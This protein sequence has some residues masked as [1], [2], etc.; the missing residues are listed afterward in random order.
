MPRTRLRL[1]ARHRRAG[2]DAFISYSH[3]ADNELAAVLQRSLHGFARPWY[4]LR[5]MRVFRDVTN[6]PAAGL[7]STIEGVLRQS[8]YLILL[9]STHSAQ[10]EWVGREAGFWCEHKSTEAIL[11]ALTDGEIVWNDEARDF[12]MERTTALPPILAGRFA[13]EPL[14]VDLRWARGFDGLGPRHPRMREATATLAATIRGR[15]RDS[16]IGE[17]IRRHRRAIQLAAA[18]VVAIV[19]FAG[20]AVWQSFVARDQRDN[21]VEQASQA[22]ALALASSSQLQLDEHPK[23]ALL[24]ALEAYRTRQ[25]PEARSALVSALQV[26]AQSGADAVLRGHTDIARAAAFSSDGRTLVTVG[27][28][29]LVRRWKL[30][31]TWRPEP[32]LRGHTGLAIAVDLSADG[33][34]I[35]SGSWDGTV[36][37]WD[38]AGGAGRVLREGARVESVAFSPKGGL[39][40]VASGTQVEVWDY[41]ARR[42]LS[43]LDAGEDVDQVAFDPAG[44]TIAGAT[45]TSGRA[46]VWHLPTGATRELAHGS[47]AGAVA[48][49]SDGARLAVGG[50]DDRV[51]HGATNAGTVSIWDAASGRRVGRPVRT[52]TDL[53]R[54]IAFAAD[55]RTVWAAG[56]N[57]QVVHVD[58]VRARVV[59]ELPNASEANGV[60]GL[61][62]TRD[63][64]TLAVP[65]SDGSVRLWSVGP[66]TFGKALRGS[67]GDVFALA[68]SPHGE[69]VAAA[70]D[71]GGVELWDV[72]TGELIESLDVRDVAALAFDPSGRRLAFAGG[73]AIGLWSPATG[74][75][76]MLRGQVPVVSRLAF[77]ADGQ[78][79]ASGEFD[80][81]VR[82]WDVETKRQIGKPIETPKTHPREVTFVAFSPDGTHV[83]FA[84]GDYV[85]Q[86]LRLVEVRSRKVVASTSHLWPLNT[87]GVTGAPTARAASIK[88][89]FVTVTTVGPHASG[90]IRV[91]QATALAMSPDAS[92]LLVQDERG[93]V[94]AWDAVALKPLGHPFA[95]DAGEL[96][97]VAFSDDGRSFAAAGKHGA[98]RVWP[99]VFWR[100]LREIE[101]RACQAAGSSLP[102]GEWASAAPGI[103]YRASC[104]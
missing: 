76:S 85:E 6:L 42:R 46:F 83:G 55:G 21:A 65:A 25:R 41:A 60:W 47:I 45:G 67:T 23:T 66:R 20:A 68:L 80:G 99:N 53:I 37:L 34:T 39:L 95:A 69:T 31:G 71:R 8:G 82:L 73:G 30:D 5:A 27:D 59:G 100:S 58:P 24:L 63:R 33:E 86:E 13:E 32:P 43:T 36:R 81:N 1:R 102:R 101:T 12:D 56:Q 3:A 72:A 48:F 29:R 104:G 84:A 96:G 10:S 77:S 49:S 19:A 88:Y 18:T 17:D 75:V 89:P 62:I 14:L 2:Y 64:R 54:G 26:S 9:A 94:Q 98:V 22:T 79:L 11:I 35:A 7:Q 90:R 91:G 93:P 74:D 44:E 92:T 52:G 28:D 57:G 61:A 78:M 70:H 50:D 4:R 87:G 15:E 16:L 38:R 97:A 103:A 40:A 51:D